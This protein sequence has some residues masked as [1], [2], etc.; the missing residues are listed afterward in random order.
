MIGSSY[1]IKI[2]QLAL[3][4]DHFEEFQRIYE[5]DLS[6]LR[7]IKQASS[8]LRLHPLFSSLFLD[9]LDSTFSS[10]INQDKCLGNIVGQCL[11][12]TG[13]GSLWS[14]TDM[15]FVWLGEFFLTVLTLITV[16]DI[17][18]M[19]STNSDYKIPKFHSQSRHI[20]HKP[21][22]IYLYWILVLLYDL[23][24]EKTTKSA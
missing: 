24:S 14:D 20:L 11:A 7:T 9:A 1:K 15:Y 18:S 16:S 6:T 3:E 12:G 4:A 21:T 10:G 8:F 23:Y 19:A 22:L 2:S 5:Q 17:R 13:N